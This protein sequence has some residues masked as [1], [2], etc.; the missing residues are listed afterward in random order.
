[1]SSSLKHPDN[2][3][4]Q[5]LLRLSASGSSIIAELLRLSQNIPDVFL[6]PN[7]QYSPILFD[8]AYMKN[9]EQMELQINATTGMLDLD[10]EFI[11]TFSEILGRFYTLFESIVSFLE[12]YLEFIE[13]LKSGIFIEYTC[14]SVLQDKHGKQL[15]TECLY[16]YGAMLLLL[17]RHIPG[18]VRE[19]MVIAVMR[20]QAEASLE[21]LEQVCKLIR[22]TGYLGAN[23][24][25]DK[26]PKDYPEK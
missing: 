20:H 21:K 7:N 8:F 2:I 17:E 22:T 10:Q 11:D 15:M 9:S 23:A 24:P 13:S 14:E 26:Q 16:L 25:M 12:E 6:T 5:T 4:G 19:K 3:C 1:M 18:V